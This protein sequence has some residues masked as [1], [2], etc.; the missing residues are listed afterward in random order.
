MSSLPEVVAR[1]DKFLASIYERFTTIMAEAQAGCAQ[2]L[3]DNDYDT[4]AFSV[5]WSAMEN[6]AKQLGSKMSDTWDDKVSPMFDEL[7]LEPGIED[8]ERR[9]ADALDDRMEV[10]LEGMRTRVFADAAR[11]VWQR[12]VTEAPPSLSCSQCGAPMPVPSTLASVNVNCPHCS[13]VVTYEPGMRLR[14]IEHF[15][16]HPL[17]EEASW[18]Q[19]IA[20]HQADKTLRDTRG[21]TIELLKAYEHA[22]IEY[23][24]AYL[25]LRAQLLPDKAADFDKDLR[26]KMQYWYNLVDRSGPWIAAGRPRAI[27]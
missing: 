8:R 12:A 1:W 21:E 15:C 18:P 16:V 6:R 23:W 22:Q 5:A 26:G 19:W 3:V 25:T 10:E 20:R 7:D 2:L 11:A 13:A 27:V 4:S 17:A 24:R 14:S 9:K